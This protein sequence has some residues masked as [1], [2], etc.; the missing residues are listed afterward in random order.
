MPSTAVASRQNSWKR[1]AHKYRKKDATKSLEREK[2]KMQRE[3]E[4]RM[5]KSSKK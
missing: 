3:N 5:R 1:V 4:R 2:A